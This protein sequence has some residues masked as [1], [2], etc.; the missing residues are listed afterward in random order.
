MVRRHASALQ[1]A[2][3]ASDF[4]GAIVLFVGVSMFRYEDD[5]LHTLRGVGLDPALAALAYAIGWIVTV[6]LQGLYRPRARLSVRSDAVAV[7]RATALLAVISLSVLF[8]VRVPDLSRLLLL[9]LF[10][11]QAVLAILARI[12][13][14]NVFEWLRSRGFNRRFV[15][16][17]G[18]NES[19]QDFA[20]R[21]ERH[22]ELGLS[23]IGHLAGPDGV[24][25]SLTRP[26]LGQLEDIEEVLHGRVVD[27]VG[28]CLPLEAWDRVEPLT[29]LCE[30]EG[31]IVRIPLDGRGPRIAGGRAEEFDGITI[32]SLV[33]GPDR[34]ISLAMKR[35]GDVVL[36]ALGLVVLSP[37]LL[38]IA[39]WLRHVDGG[40]VIFRQ[41]RIGLHGRQ[42]ELLKFRT[43]IAGAEEMLSELETA[44]EVRG[45][46]FKL[47]DDPRMTRTG[48]FLRR[49]S[50]D[51][52]PQLWNVLR[53]EMSLVGPRPP[54]PREVEGYD[55]WH[56]RRLSMKPGMTGLWQV[57]ARRHPD[58]DRWVEMDLEYIDRW[59]LWLDFTILLRTVP[60]VIAQQGR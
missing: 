22:P 46:A 57:T 26:V 37:L 23:V 12:V 11:S 56:R 54:L 29:R 42:F 3:A 53:G 35:V 58:F 18:A 1:L 28:V 24:L 34:A 33:Y 15:L 6:W 30:D 36:A 41:T 13:L 9:I 50:L 60:A 31:K 59:S 16:V 44:N 21:I 20:D 47:T 52:L 25:P 19:G 10:A 27:E 2:L 55:V 48:P 5:W 4:V 49:T 45:R 7:M 14:R 8:I 17:A 39:L 43:M 38:A 40:P 32:L 51:E